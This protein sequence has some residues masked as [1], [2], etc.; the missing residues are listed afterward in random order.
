MYRPLL[1]AMLGLGALPAQAQDRPP[2]FPTRDVAIT[3]RVTDPQA[4]GAQMTMSWLAAS[5][6]MR[7]DMPGAGWMI[8]DHRN[9]RA[10]MVVEAGRMVM[11]L[12]MAQ[13]MQ[14]SG[15]SPNATYR[16]T[17]ND[18]V[19]GIGCSVWSYQDGGNQGS[20]CITADGV[21]LRAEGSGRGQS[22][23]MV[24]TQVTYGT[25]NPARFQRPA[26]YQSMQMPGAAGMPG[27]RPPAK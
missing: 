26:G 3:Y 21:M 11:E 17:G 4:Q 14:Q 15:P 5:Q 6:T 9:Q 12:P 2:L 27:Q 16:R 18:T 19:A 1:A 23:G 22:G 7:M 13:A 10:F 20:A 8:A 25:Q 24:A